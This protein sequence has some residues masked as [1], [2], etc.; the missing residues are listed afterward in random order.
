[1]GVAVDSNQNQCEII[2]RIRTNQRRGRR[3]AARQD[4]GR[5]DRKGSM[6]FLP[7]TAL[8]AVLST[9]IE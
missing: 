6:T 9:K 3:L 2:D 4:A 1:L 5:R 7:R 8:K